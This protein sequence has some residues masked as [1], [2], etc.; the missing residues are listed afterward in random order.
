MGDFV[1]EPVGA[2]LR[3]DVLERDGHRCRYCGV[4]CNVSPLVMDHVI[5][6]SKGGRSTI[7][8]LV[9]SCDVC[10]L[11]K[12]DRDHRRLIPDDN[13]RWWAIRGDDQFLI[14]ASDVAWISH[15][16]HQMR[17]RLQWSPS[18]LFFW[19]MI[20]VYGRELVRSAASGLEALVIGGEV[21]GATPS[22]L[23]GSAWIETF[24]EA[25]DFNIRFNER[26]RLKE[27]AD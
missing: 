25:I 17:K 26:T 23:V 16:Q 22:E 9:A 7:D 8:N 1:R 12:S 19:R 21:K 10:N 14:E 3:F 6:V 2:K 20:H 15:Q 11:G 27:R 24:E 5:P 13:H 18:F 4:R